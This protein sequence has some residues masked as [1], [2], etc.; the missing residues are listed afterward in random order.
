ME[1]YAIEPAFAHNGFLASFSHIFAGGYA[2]SYYSYK[3]SEVLEADAFTRFK[4]E[5]IFNRQTGQAYLDSILSRGDSADP[6]ELFR[7]FMG[8]D[9]DVKSLNERNFSSLNL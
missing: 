6:A 8:R 4:R 2:S 7:E 9:P 3:W 5:G 1:R